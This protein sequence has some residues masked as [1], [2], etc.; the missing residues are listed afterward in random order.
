LNVYMA[1]RASD[2]EDTISG[3]KNRINKKINSEFFGKIELQNRKILILIYD[4]DENHRSRVIEKVKSV[5]GHDD[6]RVQN[7]LRV[8]DG[9]GHCFDQNILKS[10][11][12][13]KFK[14]EN[15]LPPHPRGVHYGRKRIAHTPES[16]RGSWELINFIFKECKVSEYK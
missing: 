9:K 10:I 3:L 4:I 16:K 12:R 11:V 6:Q 13:E 14:Y 7:N 1:H 2:G 8:I 5:C 15:I